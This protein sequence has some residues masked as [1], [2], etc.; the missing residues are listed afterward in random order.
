MGNQL[1]EHISKDKLTEIIDGLH[2]QMVSCDKAKSLFLQKSS[3]MFLNRNKIQVQ[4]ISDNFEIKEEIDY[5]S[6]G[7]SQTD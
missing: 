6:N 2:L 7:N 3:K 5:E 1:Q 4:N